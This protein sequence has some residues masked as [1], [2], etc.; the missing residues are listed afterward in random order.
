MAD[1]FD[2]LSEA[3]NKCLAARGMPERITSKRMAE[4]APV[5]LMRSEAIERARRVTETA[6]TPP[7]VALVTPDAAKLGTEGLRALKEQW[8]H[9]LEVG[10]RMVM[11]SEGRAMT[12]D[13]T[14]QLM[15][16]VTAKFTARP[17]AEELAKSDVGSFRESLAWA[18][19]E[20]RLGSATSPGLAP[21]HDAA[22][23]A[24]RHRVEGVTTEDL[25]KLTSEQF[26][27]RMKSFATSVPFG[28]KRIDG[29]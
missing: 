15:N 13:E 23:E 12:Q 22:D 18:V 20:G 24:A 14:H 26:H 3:M 5:A 2:V 8:K 28:A 7:K 11:E 25:S 17:S 27:E 19:V 9:T 4:V 10:E 16:A 21:L 29:R 1:I 6:T